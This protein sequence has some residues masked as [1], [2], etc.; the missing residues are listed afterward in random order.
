MDVA[1]VGITGARQQQ[2]VAVEFGSESGELHRRAPPSAPT[3]RLARMGRS[4]S[5]VRWLPA[6]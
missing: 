4:S 1:N 2:A 3:H 5:R 6:A